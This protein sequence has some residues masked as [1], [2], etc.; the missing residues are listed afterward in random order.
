[1]HNSNKQ[2]CGFS[3]E[4]RFLSNFYPVQITIDGVVYQSSEH[5]YMSQKTDDQLIRDRIIEAKTPGIAKRLG[6]KIKL[7]PDWNEK[8]KMKSMLTAVLH[9]FLAPEM[10][11]RLDATD[12]A[13]L[14][15][16]N[17]W[18]DVYWG[19]CDGVGENWLGKILMHTRKTYRIA[20]D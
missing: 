9:K 13:Y 14:E 6:A 7:R 19:V 5:Y 15:E 18:G 12:D 20:N 2:I 10:W 1:M 16:T 11:E 17:H 8:Y 3:G 4:Y